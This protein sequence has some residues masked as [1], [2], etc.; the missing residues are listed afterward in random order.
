MLYL[1]VNTQQLPLSNGRQFSE[2]ELP[3]LAPAN[4]GGPVAVVSANPNNQSVL[5]LKNLSTTSW[6]AVLPSGSVKQIDP[7]RTVKLEART[8]VILGSYAA[9]VI[10]LAASSMSYGQSLTPKKQSEAL[11]IESGFREVVAEREDS[12]INSL[13]WSS[14]KR[15]L[16]AIVGIGLLSG[17]A[18]FAINYKPTSPGEQSNRTDP[19]PPPE[20]EPQ[21]PPGGEVSAGPSYGLQSTGYRSQPYVWDPCK[22]DEY[23]SIDQ[24][25][26][27]QTW[28]PVVGPRSSL[29]SVLSRCRADAFINKSGNVQVASFRDRNTARSFAERLNRDSTHAFQFWVGDPTVR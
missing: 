4:A 7:D 11:S 9:E 5:G 21:R 28:W 22:A 17:L 8:K 19:P 27:G 12:S 14:P 1:S 6:Q 23:Q 26:S 10:D 13:P 15:W 25:Q 24:A 3:G 16:P 2:A 20:A 18:F 29:E